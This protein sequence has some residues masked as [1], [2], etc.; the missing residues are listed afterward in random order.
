MFGLM[1]VARMSGQPGGAF[2]PLSLFA[3]SEQGA[4]FDPS[5]FS[6][7]FQ[8]SAGTTPVTAVEQPVGRIN[9]KSGNGNHATQA[10]AAARP[11]LRQDGGGNYYLETDGIDDFL[12]STTLPYS[13]ART[14]LGA[15]FS[16]DTGA[17]NRT[18]AASDLESV[19][20]Y[21]GA[22]KYYA[23]S[24]PAIIEIAAS[25]RTVAQVVGY[26]KPSNASANTLS[27]LSAVTAFTPNATVT[28]GYTLGAANAIGGS[29]CAGRIYGLVVT[30]YMQTETQRQALARYLADKAG[31]TL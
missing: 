15:V 26:E 9:D 24:T 1:G 18:F 2:S 10:T 5:D 28:A 31:I 4:W 16:T 30:N 12:P 14:V 23:S 22:W 19:F 29:P 17:V 13:A 8:D 11:I 21:L 20:D 7:M 6:S 3:A 27:G 25:S